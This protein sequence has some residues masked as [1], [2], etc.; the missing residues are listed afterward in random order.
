LADKDEARAIVRATVDLARSLNMRVTA[1]GVETTQQLQQVRIL[2][3]TEIQGYLL[4]A[5]VPA[6]EILQLLPSVP[7]RADCSTAVSAG[8]KNGKLCQVR[9]DLRCSHHMT[10]GECE[11]LQ[12][13]M[14]GETAEESARHLNKSPQLIGDCRERVERKIGA[15]GASE[16]IQIMMT[17]GCSS[18][19]PK[20]ALRPSQTSATNSAVTSPVGSIA[21]PELS[22]EHQGSQRRRV[23]N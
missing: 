16:V 10:G 7:G 13:I 12:G 11:A 21:E 3:C 22:P 2:G 23:V 1:E 19:R 18:S 20:P 6:A 9:P 17:K 14:A 8:R 15:N 5:P 4:S